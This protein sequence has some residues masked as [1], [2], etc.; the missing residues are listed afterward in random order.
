MEKVEVD[1]AGR[2]KKV[3]YKLDPVAGG[4]VRL[5]IDWRVQ[6]AAEKAMEDKNGA[7]IAMSPKTGEVF[8]ITSHPNFDPNLFVSG[9]EKN[10]WSKIVNNP[11]HPLQNK[12]IQGIFPPGSTFKIVTALAALEEG[13]INRHTSFY[14]NGK[15]RVGNRDFRC[16]KDSGHGSVDV[17]KAMVESCD[18]F[19]YEVSLKLGAE[20]LAKY[21]RLLGLGEKTEINIPGE[22]DGIV[23]SP[24][25]KKERYKKNWVDG[26][27]LPFAIGQG[28]LTISP[29]QLAV[30]YSAFVNGGYVIKPTVIKE[31]EVGDDKKVTEDVPKVKSSVYLNPE[32]IDIVRKG[33]IGVVNEPTGTGKTSKLEN[34]IVAGKT[35][36]AQVRSFKERKKLSG[37]M[38]DHAWFVAFAPAYDPEIVVSV[39]VMHGGHGGTV[40]APIAKKVLEAFF[41][42]DK[43]N[44][45]NNN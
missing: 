27:T 20:K 17:H 9:F 29:I 42:K 39:F 10:E 11:F 8:A 43:H 1:G 33:L 14:C 22:L 41:Y 4:S 16:W 37:F 13:I 31:I 24:N 32:T 25:W 21:A 23:P 38:N 18:V 40:A 44:G 6:E 35:G 45:K 19:F 2:K 15:K 36:T 28:Y 5:T 12:A 3:L 7:V 26:D 34:I 30:A